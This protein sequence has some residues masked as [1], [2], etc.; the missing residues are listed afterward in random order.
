MKE[1]NN[2]SASEGEGVRGNWLRFL[3]DS[4]RLRHLTSSGNDAMSPMAKTRKTS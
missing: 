2:N 1:M 3:R 4:P